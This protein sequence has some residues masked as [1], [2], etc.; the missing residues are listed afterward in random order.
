[1]TL[2]EILSVIDKHYSEGLDICRVHSGD[3]SI[4][5]AINEQIKH[6]KERSMDFEVIPGVSSVFAAASKIGELTEPGLSQSLIIT[7]VPVRTDYIKSEDLSEL[8]KHKSTMAILLSAARAREVTK[9]LIDA[10]FS[11]DDKLIIAYKI[12]WPDEKI[13]ETT[14]KNL[15]D[16]LFNNKISRQ[17][18]IF[19]GGTVSFSG[20]KTSNLYNKKFTHM[21]RKGNDGKF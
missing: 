6:F 17:A 5:G 4:Y 15:E 16:E 10:G 21:F 19:A 8:A 7:R 11:E 14:V 20:G 2:D 9:K 3:P 1:M 13:I 18:I 12:S